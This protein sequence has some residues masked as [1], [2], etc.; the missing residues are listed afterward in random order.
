MMSIRRLYPLLV[1]LAPFSTVAQRVTVKSFQAGFGAELSGAALNNVTD[2]DFDIIH[3]ALLRYKV[4]VVRNQQDLSVEGQRSLTRRFGHLHVHLES[5]SH[6]PGYTDVNVVSNIKN[7]NGSYIGL[8]GAHVE[9]LHSDLS[10]H[11]LP[12]KVTMLK[13]VILPPQDYGDTVFADT[14][15]A[16][17]DLSD[18]MKAKLKG[19]QGSFSYLKLRDIDD[20]GRSENLNVNEVKVAHKPTIHPL[21][22]THPV[23]G[24]KN[25]YANPSHTVG[26]VGYDREESNRLLNLLF[27]HTAKP[28]YAYRH[29][30]REGD[31]LMWDNRAVHHR[32]TGC[33]DEF[34]RKLIRTTASND[35]IPRDNFVS[36]TNS[37][38]D[39][40]VHKFDL[41]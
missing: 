4:I 27:D 30:W 19:L 32:A 5:T 1:V 21:I 28:E 20:S 11:P 37:T 9:N 24:R 6:L 41:V 36:V 33:P 10:W 39:T 22:T 29:K 16:Y 34:P 26:I 35:D 7:E 2:T 15:S 31:L 40:A 17:D 18:E 8:Y 38:V 23:T 25:I 12:T 13:A 14:H 3:D